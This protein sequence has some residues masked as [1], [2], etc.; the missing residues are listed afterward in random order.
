MRNWILAGILVVIGAA[1]YAAD[2]TIRNHDVGT[3]TDKE[4]KIRDLGDGTFARVT[5]DFAAPSPTLTYQVRF[6]SAVA[7]PISLAPIGFGLS[8]GF[9]VFGGTATFNVNG[10]DDIAVLSGKSITESFF[11][12][13]TNPVLNLIGLGPGATAHLIIVIAE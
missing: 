10:G 3:G 8:W 2:S 11:G 9:E 4:M 13:V 6:A 7:A 1:A 5:S 12:L